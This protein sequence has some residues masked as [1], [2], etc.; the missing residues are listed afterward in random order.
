MSVHVCAPCLHE[1]VNQVLKMSEF[2]SEGKEHHKTQ[3]VPVKK[4]KRHKCIGIH[5]ESLPW[6]SLYYDYMSSK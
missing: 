2:T 4:H 5:N 3:T 6:F 1:G